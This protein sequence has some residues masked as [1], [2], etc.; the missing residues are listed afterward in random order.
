[1]LKCPLPEFLSTKRDNVDFMCVCFSVSLCHLSLVGYSW[2]SKIQIL[3][4]DGKCGV[5][6]IENVESDIIF[7]ENAE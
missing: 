4:L 6:S 7:M 5:Q 1:M 2:I 3:G